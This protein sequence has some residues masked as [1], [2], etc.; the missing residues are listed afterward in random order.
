M[1]KLRE[2]RLGLP[3][4]AN[5]KAPDDLYEAVEAERAMVKDDKGNPI[6]L[7]DFC[8]ILVAIGVKVHR[9]WRDQAQVGQ[10]L[11]VQPTDAQIQKVVQSP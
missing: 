7:S 8:R 6:G 5:E 2:V 3:K 1:V 9:E 11:I 10:S 4:K